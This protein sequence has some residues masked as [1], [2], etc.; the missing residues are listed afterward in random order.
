M[1]VDGVCVR[2]GGGGGKTRFSLSQNFK[3]YVCGKREKT[4]IMPVNFLHSLHWKVL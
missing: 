3:L 2:G 4:I 1:S